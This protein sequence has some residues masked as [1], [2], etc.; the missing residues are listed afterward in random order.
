MSRAKPFDRDGQARYRGGMEH[1]FGGR[2]HP[3]ADALREWV[4]MRA[5]LGEDLFAKARRWAA[6]A[7]HDARPGTYVLSTSQPGGVWCNSEPAVAAVGRAMEPEVSRLLG[8][9][10]WLSYGGLIV[11]FRGVPVV[12]HRDIGSGSKYLLSW[13]AALDIEGGW[14]LYAERPEGGRTVVDVLDH[15]SAER[16]LLFAGHDVH[17]WR[18]PYPGKVGRLM[19]CRYTAFDQA[20]THTEAEI[21][22]LA[23]AGLA[24]LDG[25]PADVPRDLIQ[26]RC[27][28]QDLALANRPCLTVPGLLTAEECATLRF[29]GGGGAR[30]Q[31]VA[32]RLRRAV[33]EAA[34]VLIPGCA[35]A[36]HE[37][38]LAG[39][40]LLSAAG[41]PL[42][43]ERGHRV[44]AALCLETGE[45]TLWR[46]DAPAR[47][48]GGGRVIWAAYGEP[49]SLRRRT[50]RLGT[51]AAR[52]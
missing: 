13:P 2:N 11:H 20:R 50:A 21:D 33:S 38:R 3:E 26:A 35:F 25:R 45:A 23:D 48:R 19:F 18:G 32:R 49:P 16:A 5:A 51:R 15:A 8:R 14:P 28:S 44:Y 12:R 4:D 7:A 27:T 40:L 9:R 24:E 1:L 43:P 22:R 29:A 17:H 52:E 39:P 34:P 47:P 31:W 30:L 46:A 10:A 36:G 41:I 37:V 6:A 42:E